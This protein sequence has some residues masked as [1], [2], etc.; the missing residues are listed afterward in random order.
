MRL[1]SNNVIARKI[2]KATL[3]ILSGYKFDTLLKMSVILGNLLINGIFLFPTSYASPY[4]NLID[5]G[6]YSLPKNGFVSMCEIAFINSSRVSHPK[7]GTIIVPSN[8][9]TL[10]QP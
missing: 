7:C 5:V 10:Q 2:S 6:V 4:N 3:R 1:S 9:C 8:V